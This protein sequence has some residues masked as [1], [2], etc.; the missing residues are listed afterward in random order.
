MDDWTQ[1]GVKGAAAGLVAGIPQ[2]LLTQIEARVLGLPASQADIGPRFVQRIAERLD[3]RPKGPQRWL[4]AAGFHFGYAAGWGVVY[5]LVQRWRP[6]QPHVGGPLL[7]A[8]I[9]ALAFSPMGSRHANGYRTPCPSASNA[10]DAHALDRCAVVQPDAGLPVRATGA[11]AGS[12]P[13]TDAVTTRYDAVVVGA[14]PERARGCHRPCSG[15]AARAGARGG[16]S[17]GRGRADRRAHPP[18]LS[19]R[20]L[21]RGAS[22]RHRFALLSSPAPGCPRSGMDSAASRG[23]PSVRRWH[24]RPPRAFHTRYGSPAWARCAGLAGVDGPVRQTAGSHCSPTRS[25]RSS[26]RSHPFLLARFGLTALAPRRGSPAASS[27]RRAREPCS[28]A[29]RHTQRSPCACRPARRSA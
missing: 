3:K 26:R 6:A 1:I 8:L 12:Q 21:L 17:S 25:G 16:R 13:V 29:W 2:V 4:I 15:R 20:R 27:A 14:G 5:A 19:A 10:R 24:G 11:R 28:L 18:G 7:A 23:C 22:S 9:Y